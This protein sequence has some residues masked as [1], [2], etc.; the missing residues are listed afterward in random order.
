MHVFGW[1]KATGSK[2]GLG[3]TGRRKQG[4][5]YPAQV[6]DFLKKPLD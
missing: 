4:F 1:I 5:P 2:I 3:K 6:M